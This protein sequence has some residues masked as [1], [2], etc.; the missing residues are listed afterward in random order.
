ML[1][2]LQVLVI[3]IDP[4]VSMLAGIVLEAEGHQITCISEPQQALARFHS[5]ESYDVVLFDASRQ[6]PS[7]LYLLEALLKT[8]GTA[9][10]CLLVPL[11]ISLWKLDAERLGIKQSLRKPLQRHD[12]EQLFNSV[13]PSSRMGSEKSAT[14]N[15]PGTKQLPYYLE[16]LPGGRYFLAGCQATLKIY[17]TLRLLA[18]VDVP[19]LILGESGVGKD[20]FANLLHTHS[21]RSRESYLSVNCAALPS[22]LL[23][24]ELF[25]Y[26][27]GAFTGAVKAKQGKFELANRGTILLDEIGEMSAPM[28]AKLLHVLQ[29]GRFSKLGSRTTTQVDVRI[30]AATNINIENA[31]AEQTFRA[32]LYYRISAFSVT[33]PPLRER[34]EEIPFFVE[35][36]IRRQAKALRQPAIYIPSQLMTALQ[37]YQ[38]PGNL[39]E[40]S[41]FV[42]RMLILQ[43]P[44]T[45]LSDLEFKMRSRR[46]SASN[47]HVQP[48]EIAQEA[49]S[50]QAIVRNFKDKT[51][52]RLIQ[53]AL[54]ASGWNR[55]HAALQL[56]ISYRGMLYKIQQY[57]LKESDSSL[58]LRPR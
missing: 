55:R 13:S 58:H 16:E 44:D 18:P 27:A 15:S 32:D 52:S 9:K 28:Q 24:S 37:E 57:N 39:R 6:P 7:N 34:K 20:V 12:L 50:M 21:L 51:E 19:V 47:L 23:E 17:N 22:D 30:A 1:R 2:C 53:E 48:A 36:M 33:I 38:W 5:G 35:E 26:E 42:I 40:L 45:A 49:E 43:D 41:N 56:R 11:G 25:G 3:T 31:L 54:E 8:A 46:N 10:L 14:E 29:D 4:S